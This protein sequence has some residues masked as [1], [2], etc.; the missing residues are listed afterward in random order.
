MDSGLAPDGTPRNDGS[1]AQSAAKIRQNLIDLI[2]WARNASC[3]T[4]SYREAISVLDQTHERG[5][6]FGHRSAAV[7]EAQIA[8]HP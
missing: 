5:G 3:L 2:E 4:K 8:I 7:G 1:T 6:V